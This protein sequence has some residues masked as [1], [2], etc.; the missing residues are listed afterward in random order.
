MYSLLLTFFFLALV[1][2]FF[3]SLWEAVL[4]SIT[5]SHARLEFQQGTRVGRYLED[6]KANVD[7][8][9]AAILTLNTI[10][11]TAG[12]IGV[13][14]QAASIWAEANPWITRIAVP[15]SMTIAILVFSEIV[16]KTIGA[17]YWQY[18]V[19]FTVH[20]LRLLTVGLAPFVWLSQYITR[21]L[22]RG[23]TQPVL[24]RTDFVA[25]AELGAQEGVFEA[26]ESAMIGHLIRFQTI[27]AGDVMTPRTVVE[28]AAE[29][30]SIA[31]YYEK[32]KNLPFSRIPLHDETKDQ[33]TGYFLCTDLMVALLDG[34]GDQPI[35]ALRRDIVAVDQSY[36]ITDLF[37]VLRAR[38]E[39]LAVVLDDFGGMAGI[40][41]ME[42]II[43][44]L[45]GLEIVDETDATTDMRE[46]ARRH[47]V[48]RA[49]ALGALEGP[50]DQAEE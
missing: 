36:A 5:P 42:D 50:L 6:F 35:A 43:E 34:R 49:K 48:M 45:L 13:G 38:Q 46:L 11:H 47:R 39:H 10:A 23:T 29:D 4:L 27:Q 19:T 12:A 40:V 1:F 37:T 41:T 21:R 28:V 7:R 2:S 26:E 30:E 14:D 8:P 32:A 17:L 9:L 22:K 15:A 18:F 31:G 16:P 33:I 25:M 44:T 3:C 24:T 20:S